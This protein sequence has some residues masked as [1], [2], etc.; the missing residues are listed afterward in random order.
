MTTEQRPA[1]S[2]PTARIRANVVANFAGNG[3]NTIISIV[4]V[5]VYI[6][7]MGI[8]SYG[9]VGLF[10]ALTSIVSLL[11]LGISAVLSR[12]IPRLTALPGRE[13]QVR[14][15]VR[16]LEYLYWPLGL[17][18]GAILLGLSPLIAFH[19][20][21]AEQ[22]SP[23]AAQQALMLM[24]AATGGIFIN[25]FY[26]AGLFALQR[27][28]LANVVGAA[29]GTVRALGTVFALWQIAPT[30]QVFAAWQAIV[31]VVQLSCTLLV[32]WRLLP[33][34]GRPRP[35]GAQ[36]TRVWRFA[37]GISGITVLAVLLTQ[38]DKI[39]LSRTLTLTEFGYYALANAMAT[40][41]GRV[42]GPVMTA[43]FP[44]LTQLVTQ[45]DG[46]GLARLYHASCQLMA[47]LLVPIATVLAV[48]AGPVLLVWT[49]DPVTSANTFGVMGLLVTGTALN[50]LY[51]IPYALQLAHGWTRLSLYSNL[52]AVAV[53]LPLLYL[54]AIRFGAV[55]AGMVW[56][57]LNAGYLL[58][59]APIMFRKLLPDEMWSWYRRDLVLPI[60]VAVAVAGALRPWVGSAWGILPMA[61][62][63]AFSLAVTMLVTLMAAPLIRTEVL[64]LLLSWRRPLPSAPSH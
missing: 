52:I 30:I 46:V 64:R 39:I 4:L 7:F 3:W 25:G 10:A 44:R 59:S 27:Q 55:G 26:A 9:L 23:L 54:A 24:S 5:P 32:L 2:M 14:D 1:G 31:T 49:R 61:A 57:A 38:L 8:E 53:L 17:A 36:L 41:L 22:L 43:T 34:G 35:G 15:L 20:L 29:F 28:V 18:A 56:V 12:E 21:R 45:R 33:A 6:R 42:V 19:W 48:Y 47:V 11:D 13:Q 40:G 51:H 60:V 50:G 62:Y 16:T 37:A 63:L 58:F